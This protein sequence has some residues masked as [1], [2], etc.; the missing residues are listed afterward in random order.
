MDKFEYI[1]KIEY[2]KKGNPHWL[3]QIGKEGWEMIGLIPMQD[4][5]GTELIRYYFKRKL[6]E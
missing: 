5:D 6:S 2:K 3:N 1:T 4:D